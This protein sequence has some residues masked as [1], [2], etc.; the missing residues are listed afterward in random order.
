MNDRSE[1]TSSRAQ[2]VQELI[3]STPSI[4]AKIVQGKP[5]VHRQPD[6]SDGSLVFT[7]DLAALG[8]TIEE[9]R[10]A[11][12]MTRYV[13]ACFLG[14]WILRQNLECFDDIICHA[15]FPTLLE[16]DWYDGFGLRLINMQHLEF[17]TSPTHL[18]W[19][20][21]EDLESELRTVRI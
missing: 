19:L 8:V 2:P 14:C 3:D 12:R 4:I 5:I 16:Q 20:W 21:E 13:T 9:I 11:R 7:I 17:T 18:H 10:M 15:D 6:L 1:E